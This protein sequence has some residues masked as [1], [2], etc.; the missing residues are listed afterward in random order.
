MILGFLKGSQQALSIPGGFRGV[1]RRD[2]LMPASAKTQFFEK[3]TFAYFGVSNMS[4][5][6]QISE[7]FSTLK[8]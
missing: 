1:H 5:G 2:Q 3:S 8:F 4:L 7:Y 6:R